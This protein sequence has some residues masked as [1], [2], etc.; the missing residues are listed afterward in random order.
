MENGKED[1]VPHKL[2]LGPDPDPAPKNG[3]DSDLSVS[4]QD[5]VLNE[6]IRCLIMIQIFYEG[7]FCTSYSVSMN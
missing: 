5:L 4:D 2:R 6:H 3:P 7:Y 1:T